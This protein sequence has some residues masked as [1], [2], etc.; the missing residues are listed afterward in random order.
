M[1][2][3][4]TGIIVA[5]VMIFMTGAAFANNTNCNCSDKCNCKTTCA[6]DCTCGCKEGKPCTCTDN[7]NCKK[8][9]TCKENCNCGCTTHK[10]L[11]IKKQTCKCDENCNCEKKC[12]C[13]TEKAKKSLFHKKVKCNCAG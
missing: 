5:G 10:F 3:L 12:T 6:S 9:C 7:C 8:A 11:F 1:K 2:K 4:M 13:S